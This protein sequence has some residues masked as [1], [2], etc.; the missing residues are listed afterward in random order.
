MKNK[1]DNLMINN[2]VLM[3]KLDL[4]KNIGIA[5][6]KITCGSNKTLYWTC[7]KGHSY[8]SSVKQQVKGGCPICAGKTIIPSLN[9]LQTLEPEICEE[10]DYGKNSKSPC[11][12]SRYSGAK[13]FWKCS[14]CGHSWSTTIINRTSKGTGCPNCS[15]SKQT[16]FPEQAV[17]Y[18]V[19]KIFDKVINHY[20]IR[21]NYTID[22]YI[23]EICLG[24]EYNGF[25][26]HNSPKAIK[27][28]IEKKS[29][30]LDSGIKLI[31]INETDKM[32]VFS[33]DNSTI[34]YFRDKNDHNLQKVIRLIITDI[35]NKESPDIDILRDK[36]DILDNYLN[37]KRKDSLAYQFPETKLEWDYQK[38]APLTPDQVSSHSNIS[39]QWICPKG[40]SYIMSIDK[41][42]SG[43]SCPFCSN[44]RLLP[45]FNDFQTWCIQNNRKELLKEWDYK[46][47]LF[48]PSH[49]FMGRKVKD[50][51][52]ICSV[53]GES[54][55]ASITDRSHGKG[56]PYCFK[57]KR[58]KRVIKLSQDSII[59]AKY[60]TIT[61]AAKENNMNISN[62]SAVCRGKAKTAGGYIWKFD[63]E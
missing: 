34:T 15:T 44:R 37:C 6:E 10:W 19:S 33:F 48:L 63:D 31:C 51:F 12:Y 42:S 25:A 5:I 13:V 9:D 50:I 40:H 58:Y 7:D 61:Q 36:K 11:V 4:Q 1:M 45:G 21:N 26:W 54:W 43:Q 59:I 41:K 56:C 28:D 47:N 52:W 27:R 20:K 17:F 32:D 57:Q 38:N 14:K 16:S 62:I 49:Y 35:L 2:P 46:R 24:I 53:C 60:N 30:C 22:I 29:T 18:Y 39:V 55:C 8:P 3:R 23:S